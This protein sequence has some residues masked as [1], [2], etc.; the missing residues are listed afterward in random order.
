M[1]RSSGKVNWAKR[2]EAV[3]PIRLAV[4]DVIRC[5]Q[6]KLGMRSKVEGIEKLSVAWPDMSW[7]KSYEQHDSY[8]IDVDDNRGTYL[9]LVVSIL[10]VEV[11]G[12]DDVAPYPRLSRDVKCVRLDEK[13]WI[14]P[15]SENIQFNLDEGVSLARPDHEE[16]EI[17]GFAELPIVWNKQQK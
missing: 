8:E 2:D 11:S 9:Y 12:P 7:L 16:I 13:G 1:F 6:F 5:S 10:M 15:D 3:L 14:Y 4:G 17:V